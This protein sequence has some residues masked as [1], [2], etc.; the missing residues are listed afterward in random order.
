MKLA[1]I[2][3]K[4]IIYPSFRL[5]NDALKKYAS[6]FAC[7]SQKDNAHILPTLGIERTTPHA[8]VQSEWELWGDGRQILS[9]IV[10]CVLVLKLIDKYDLDT[11]I[12]TARQI[13][14]LIKKNFSDL[15][16][17]GENHLASL[18][19]AQRCVVELIKEYSS[20]ISEC[21]YVELTE[22]IDLIKPHIQRSKI[23]L[24][25]RCILDE[26]YR[27]AFAGCNNQEVSVAGHESVFGIDESIDLS[28]FRAEGTSAIDKMIYDEAVRVA[29]TEDIK[30]IAV[31]G[32]KAG[33][34]F[35]SLH[36]KLCAL[37]YKCTKVA[38]LPFAKTSFGRFF[39]A[40]CK[41]LALAGKFEL[42]KYIQTES[43]DWRSVASDIALSPYSSISEFDKKALNRKVS[44]K[45]DCVLCAS[46]LNTVWRQDRT[47]SAETAVEDLKGLSASFSEIES[48][49]LG[50]EEH[51]GF[52][53]L[54]EKAAR[55]RFYGHEA[56]LE[57]R[58]LFLFLSVLEYIEKFHLEINLA[59]S[60]AQLLIIDDEYSLVLKQERSKDA[61]EAFKEVTFTTFSLAK[62]IPEGFF[63][64][65]ILSDVSDEALNAK[66][67]IDS[68]A[69]LA[70]KLGFQRTETTME[71]VRTSFLS[72]VKSCAKSLVM[73][74]PSH[75]KAAEETFTS[76]CLDEFVEEVL[77]SGTTSYDLVSGKAAIQSVEVGKRQFRF[78]VQGEE[79][80]QQCFGR[81]FS[82]ASSSA[83]VQKVS[84]G[85]L[86]ELSLADYLKHA[87]KDDGRT[88]LFISP[89]AIE[90]Y[91]DCPYK[92]FL[93]RV[94]RPEAIDEGFSALEAG[95]FAHAL[96]KRFYDA[97]ME[98][99]KTVHFNANDKDEV[100]LLFQN[101][102]QM[103][104]REQ[105]DEDPASGRYVPVSNI[106]KNEAS[107]FLSQILESINLLVGLPYGFNL[108]ATEF[109]IGPYSKDPRLVEYAGFFLNGKIDR[110]DSSKTDDAFYVL[111]YKGSLTG[112][113]CGLGE[114]QIQRDDFGNKSFDPNV[115]PK[116]LQTIIYTS[117][118]LE[119]G[120][121]GM[122][123]LGAL[124]TSYK[125]KGEESLVEGSYS[126]ACSS[127]DAISNKKSRVDI[128]FGEFLGL[129]EDALASRLS[130]LK[131]GVISLSPSSKDSCKYCLYEGCKRR[132]S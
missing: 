111:D 121:F 66:T 79:D 127:L 33:Q 101:I 61:G 100:N 96:L 125:P 88:L 94:I 81:Q 56:D 64:E 68:T 43:L 82:G 124:Y 123:A 99:F 74:F 50:E 104:L 58:A 3:P 54:F 70:E 9:D 28:F 40:S 69:S 126:S 132:L 73:I 20:L 86:C 51:K 12:G 117:A 19:Y 87:K 129:V 7:S 38:S 17:L 55:T 65:V 2:E 42:D 118:V 45:L 92:W 11:S 31:I 47:L 112:K 67:K 84:R 128:S 57:T 83:L 6:A 91:I 53:S 62:S 35:E 80:V 1:L 16:N 122:N 116:H 37:G 5:A 59:P 63:D 18:S 131:N 8:F 39:M 98:K 24:H 52:A 34:L 109:E 25:S 93:N 72:A 71:E 13:S 30:K 115:L 60:I 90:D 49:F 44:S 14:D 4:T 103:L 97:V 36:E 89:S 76:F 15:V 120:V 29:P 27:S 105:A 78:L 26:P 21:G 77:G 32:Q 10:R 106:E 41:L 23:Y 46:D 48:L 114:F 95:T 75:N 119:L 102:A 108:A 113:A 110:I 107:K 85:N 22:A 130:Y